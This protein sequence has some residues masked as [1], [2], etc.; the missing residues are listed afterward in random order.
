MHAEFGFVLDVC[1]SAANAKTPAY[2]GLNHPDPTRRDGLQGNWAAEAQT[3][4]GAAWHN[5]PYGRTI[6]AWMAKACKEAAAGA[7]VVCLVPA[8]TDTRWWHDHVMTPEHEVRFVK[9]RLK[10][11]A[12]TAP[13]PFPSALIV[14][15]PEPSGVVCAMAAA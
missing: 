9:G 2:Y 8:R 1:A 4:G 15:R 5:P 14:M 3:L 11:G 13:A 7:T 12:G 10:F 6:G